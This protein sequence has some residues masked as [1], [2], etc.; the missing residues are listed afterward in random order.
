[1]TLNDLRAGETVY[2]DANIFIYHFTDQSAE[3]SMFLDRCEANE[4]RA[5]T[6]PCV[7]YKVLHRLMAIEALQRGLIRSG[8]PSKALTRAPEVTPSAL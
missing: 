3:C 8:S 2:V 7:I 5:Y 1:M 6:G 4:L